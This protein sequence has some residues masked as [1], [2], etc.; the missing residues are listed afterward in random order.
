MPHLTAEQARK[1]LDYDPNTGI[2]TWR[3]KVAKRIKIGDVAGS[4]HHSGYLTIFSHNQSHRA[5]R[6]AWLYMY[7]MWPSGC[8]DHI[9]GVKTDNRISNLRNTT[10]EI[11]MQNIHKFPKNLSSGLPGACRNGN[12]WQAYIS[13]KGK[14]TYL[15]TFKTVDEAHKV[16]MEAK[17]KYHAG[18]KHIKLPLDIR[19]IPLSRSGIKCK[20]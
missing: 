1:V 4:K 17:I 18:F 9:N 5:H 2:F 12:N 3:E 7:G 16:Y 19:R 11:N 13:I 6:L 10:H 15:G 8:I 20:C 14:P